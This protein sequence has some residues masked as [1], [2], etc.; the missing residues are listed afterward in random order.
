MNQKMLKERKDL[1]EDLK[2][3]EDF[4]KENERAKRGNIPSPKVEK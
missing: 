1:M 2:M 3:I 4:D